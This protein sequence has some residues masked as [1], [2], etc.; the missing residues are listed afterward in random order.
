MTTLHYYLLPFGNIVLPFLLPAYPCLPL[1]LLTTLLPVQFHQ[2]PPLNTL[3]PIFFL[4]PTCY[5]NLIPFHRRFL[6]IFLT[7]NRFLCLTFNH[8]LTLF[9]IYLQGTL[10]QNKMTAIR[11]FCP[12]MEDEV[13]LIS[14]GGHIDDKGKTLTWH[15]D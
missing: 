12:G 15:S 8:Y 11:A 9:Y 3:F 6:A 14:D 7:F 1:S 4:H 13:L 10:T 2:F 5:F